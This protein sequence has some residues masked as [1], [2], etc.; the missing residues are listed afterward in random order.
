MDDLETFLKW[1]CEVG[2]DCFPR[3][4]PRRSHTY[5]VTVYQP[6]TQREVKVSGSSL[7]VSLGL[8]M[9]RWQIPSSS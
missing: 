8:A 4:C 5:D 2:I 1:G 7:T 6:T 9:K 3:S